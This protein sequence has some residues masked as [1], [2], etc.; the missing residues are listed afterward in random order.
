M[1]TDNVN[2]STGMRNQDIYSTCE[3]RVVEKG[4]KKLA[5]AWYWRWPK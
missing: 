3:S 2:N 4:H 5:L 1:N